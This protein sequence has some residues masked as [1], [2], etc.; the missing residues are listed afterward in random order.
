MKRLQCIL[1]A[2]L[3]LSAC[4]SDRNSILKVYNWSTYIDESVIPEF[5][6]WYEE[7]TG[8][9]VTVIYQTF[10]VLESMLSKIEKGHEDY[11][12]VCPS[13]YMIERMLR[14]NLLLPLDRNFG[15]TP[16]YIGCVSPFITGYFN[17]IDAPGYNPS[18]YIAGYMWGTTGILYN[19]R[20]VTDEE[21][22]SWEILRNPKFKDRI[23]I[24]DAARDVASQLIIHTH[25]DD[26]EAGRVTRD[27]LM[28]DYSDST[29]AAVEAFLNEAKQYA[30]G[31]EA[32]F[33]K[34]QMIKERGWVNLNWSGDSQWAIVEAAE[35]GV[36]LRFSCP[37][38]GYTIFFDGWVIPKYAGNVKAANYWIDYMCR[39]DVALR[40]SDATGYVS[41][42]AD[43]S[44]LEALTDPELEPLDAS[45]FFGPEAA[46][47]R[48]DP[49]MYPDASDI[50]RSAMEH[51]WGEQTEKL[52]SMWSRIKGSD[53]NYLTVIVIGA[54]V[55]LLA[56]VGIRKKSGG[57]K[58]R[59]GRRR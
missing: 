59:H 29:L 18:D 8:E 12:V 27:E 10:D 9:K 50:S 13:D 43:S 51:D 46:E 30:A 57:K 15:E 58:K 52:I 49:V 40:N 19:A 31:W 20:Y 2:L 32:D 28:L 39:P 21:A 17:R 36:D 42:I 37:K 56:F 34:E 25:I 14:S 22:S 38:E 55:L 35:V 5:E 44:V 54:A 53:A 48:L 6:Q 1:L 23:F 11:D 16:D 45:Y 3:T 24:K 26:I 4:S 47:A 33:G 41:C 7:Q